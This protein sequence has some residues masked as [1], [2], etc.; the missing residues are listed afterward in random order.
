MTDGM[1]WSKVIVRQ[2]QLPLIW[3]VA[4]PNQ[5]TTEPT[6]ANV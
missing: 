5:A 4:Q 2:D 1:I 6:L 3:S